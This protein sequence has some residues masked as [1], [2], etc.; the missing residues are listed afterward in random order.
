MLSK[1]VFDKATFTKVNF[2]TNQMK[3]WWNRFK[4]T[5]NS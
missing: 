5:K 3:H 1:E 4:T 2:C